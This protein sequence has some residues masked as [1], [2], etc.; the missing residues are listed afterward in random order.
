MFHALIW[1]FKKMAHALIISKNSLD[2]VFFQTSLNFD[3]GSLKNI[4]SPTSEQFRGFCFDW[5][6]TPL[7]DLQQ[8]ID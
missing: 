8:Q 7:F 3:L 4:R 2:T 1:K 6:A 5:Y